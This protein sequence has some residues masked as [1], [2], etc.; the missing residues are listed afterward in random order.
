MEEEE[1]LKFL[2]DLDKDMQNLEENGFNMQDE[3]LEDVD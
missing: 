2:A 3:D 1:I